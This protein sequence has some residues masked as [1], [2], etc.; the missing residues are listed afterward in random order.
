MREEV[1][2]DNSYL[3]MSMSAHTQTATTTENSYQLP[4]WY[5]K[6]RELRRWNRRL[7][8]VTELKESEFQNLS[9]RWVG[10]RVQNKTHIAFVKKFVGTEQTR[11][12]MKSDWWKVNIRY[13]VFLRGNGLHSY[14]VNIET[15]RYS[16]LAYFDLSGHKI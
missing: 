16:Y 4:R 7:K 11:L 1:R 2:A 8:V 10:T 15:W 3:N 13:F 14:L 9:K 12:A 6:Y 5:E